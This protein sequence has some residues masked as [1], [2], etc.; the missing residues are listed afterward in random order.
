MTDVNHILKALRNNGEQLQK[1]IKEALNEKANLQPNPEAFKEETAGGKQRVWEKKEQ[2]E[3]LEHSNAQMKQVVNDKVSQ[4]KSEAETML[5]IRYC[6]I[7]LEIT[8]MTG[9]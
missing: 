9:T 6:L 4:L 1:K 2:M 7:L 8:W 3:M 5:K